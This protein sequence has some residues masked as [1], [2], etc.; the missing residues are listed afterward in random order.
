MESYLPE[1]KG[2]TQGIRQ[3]RNVYEG[4]Q[5]GWGLQ[6]G[7]LREKVLGRRRSVSPETAPS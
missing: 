2:L 6:F 1:L 7:G 3:G 5:R 4:Y